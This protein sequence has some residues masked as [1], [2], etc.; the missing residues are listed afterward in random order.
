MGP[1][2]HPSFSGKKYFVPLYDD[3]SGVSLVRFLRKRD[4]AGAAIEEMIAE[5]EKMRKGRVKQL[6]IT[7][8]EDENVKRLRSGN[9][10]E[11]LSRS[12]TK[13]LLKKG[14]HHEL[15]S[16]CSPESKRKAERLNRTLLDMARTML[17]GAPHLPKKNQ[18]WAEAVNAA[19]H[20]RNRVFSTAS[21]APT[22]TLYE[23]MMKKKPNLSHLKIFG[24]NAYFHIPKAKRKG[25]FSQRAR[26]GYLAWFESGKSFRVYLPK[27]DRVVVSRD[28]SIDDVNE[29]KQSD[30]NDRD[31][32][33]NG[34]SIQFDD[35]F[36]PF[37]DNVLSTLSQATEQAQ[38]V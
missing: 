16:A 4:E 35:P 34:Y 2:K 9:A 17:I 15:R 26:V 30:Q 11:F 27:E 5:L 25:K 14:M 3:S 36:K 28:V 10:K 7:V 38:D 20:I 19:C 21:T 23:L 1:I 24:S 18:M 8:Y 22:M 6:K 13:W 12:F 29:I 37:S 31:D 33:E 32:T